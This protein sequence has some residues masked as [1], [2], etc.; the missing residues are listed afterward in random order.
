MKKS[1]D[2]RNLAKKYGRAIKGA[3]KLEKQELAIKTRDGLKKISPLDVRY[4]GT[5]FGTM[6]DMYGD[7]S[8]QFSEYKK[9][10]GHSISRFISTFKSLGHITPNIE[11]NALIDEITSLLVLN[12]NVTYFNF[13]R[14][15]DGYVTG[16][17]QID[18]VT[19]SHIEVPEDF[20]KGYWVIKDGEFVLDEEKYR[21]YWSI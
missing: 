19:T 15:K 14:D 13:T 20:D 4:E 3:P 9:D 8:K 5:T 6:L 16:K 1:K 2:V 17:Q 18:I 7:V 21:Q 10:V 11:L 12:P